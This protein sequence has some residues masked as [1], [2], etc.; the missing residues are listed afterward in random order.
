MRLIGRPRVVNFLSPLLA[1]LISKLIGPEQAPALSRAIVDAGLKLLSLEMSDQEK[2]GLAASAVAATVEET[3]NRVASLPDHILDNQELLEGFALEAFEQA[4]AANLPAVLSQATYRQ[5]PDLL[6]AGVNAAWL[7][8]PLRG[9][10]RYKRCTRSFKVNIT[11]HMAEEIESFEG[12]PLS[13]YLQDQLGL[14][15]GAEVEAEVHLYEAL[16]GT[17]VA[18][19]ARSETETP[20]LGCR[21]KLP[22]RNCI[23]SHVTPHPRCSETPVSAVAR[24]PGSDRQNLPAGQ[25]L[26]HLAIPGRR[27]LTIPGK[28][29][30]RRVRRLFHI[31]VTLDSPQD[32]IRVCIYVS[33]VEDFRSWP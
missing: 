22:S 15:E 21:T 11:P 3:V 33:K 20:G 18:D 2:S 17:T 16:P 7:L 32:R 8:M 29:G 13:D 6:E 19:I 31:N 27:P 30:R 25:R 24:S 28:S 26:F 14:P 9:R 5:R 12:V 4:A 23:R 1:K 10:K